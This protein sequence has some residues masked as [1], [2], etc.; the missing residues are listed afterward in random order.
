VDRE[1]VDHRAVVVRAEPLAADLDAHEL[2]LRALLL[3]L[4]ERL[5]ADEVGACSRSTIQS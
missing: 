4:R 3:D 5:L 1:H 2:A